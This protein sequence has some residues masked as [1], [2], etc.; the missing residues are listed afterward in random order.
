MNTN[1]PAPGWYFQFNDSISGPH[2]EGEAR[3]MYN[4]AS[5]HGHVRVIRIDNNG[6]K[7]AV[8]DSMPQTVDHS[9]REAAELATRIFGEKVSSQ[10]AYYAEARVLFWGLFQGAEN[11]GL[12]EEV[13]NGFFLLAQREEGRVSKLVHSLT[14]GLHVAVVNAL[15]AYYKEN[16]G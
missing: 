10:N 13:R 7:V 12:F 6:N 3:D 14:R 11:K 8:L 9:A 15:V 1:A 2:L 4:G 16:K 5:D